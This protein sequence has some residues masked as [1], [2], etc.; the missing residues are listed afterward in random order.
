MA[1]K[2]ICITCHKEKPL[3]EF[4][5]NAL[6]VSGRTNK[7]KPCKKEYMKGYQ[8]GGRI[9]I[10]FLLSMRKGGKDAWSLS[11]VITFLAK[12]KA[13]L[14]EGNTKFDDLYKDSGHTAVG[15]KNLIAELRKLAKFNQ[16]ERVAGRPEEGL[17][18]YW[19]NGRRFR[20]KA[21]KVLLVAGK[22]K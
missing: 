6:A 16:E 8:S 9:E 11:Q 18:A 21:T 10:D 1:N 5:K 22:K 12:I 2:K 13:S 19:N 14:K 15:C 4:H 7:C 20:Y 17:K 3:S